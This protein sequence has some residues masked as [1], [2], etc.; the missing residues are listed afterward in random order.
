MDTDVLA[1]WIDAKHQLLSQLR[2]LAARQRELVGGGD[3]TQL[4]N[5][6]GVKQRL[7]DVVTTVESRLD[8]FRA[9]DPEQRVWRTPEHR[10]RTRAVSQRCDELLREILAIERDCE[11]KMLVRRDQAANQLQRAHFSTN[12]AQA[13]LGAGEVAGGRFDASCET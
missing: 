13:Y 8:P 1:K 12:A 9:E 2:E 5:L 10:I 11:S 7:L 4:M 6:L 3:V